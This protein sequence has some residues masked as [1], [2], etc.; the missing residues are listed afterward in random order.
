MRQNSDI[1]LEPGFLLK[2]SSRAPQ[3]TF[4]DKRKMEETIKG[5]TRTLL[6]LWNEEGYWWFT[7][8]ANEA[9]GAGFIQLMHFLEDVDSEIEKGLIQRM[10]QEQRED[11]SWGLYYAA[12]GDLSTTVECYLSLRLAGFSPS[13]APLLKAKKF[14]LSEGGLTQIRIFTRIHLALFG[15]I[16]WSNCPSMPAEMILLPPWAPMNVYHFSSWAR[17]SIIPLLVVM[18]TK[19]ALKIQGLDLEALYC[20]PPEKRKWTLPK[21]TNPLSLEQLFLLVDTG[22]KKLGKVPFKP[23]RKQVLD[24]CI[25]WIW[26]HIQKTHD[27]YPALAYGAMAFKACGYANETKQIQTALKALKSF[28]QRDENQM[29]QQCCISPVWDTPW[30]MVALQESGLITIDDPNLLKTG[31]WLLSKEIVN[32][33]GDWHFKNPEGEPGGWSFE[34]LNE[35]FPDVDDTIEVITALDN[36]DLPEEEKRPAIQRGLKW[37]LSM[38]N[39]DGGWGAFDKNNDLDLVNKIPFADHGACLDPSTPDIT[40]RALELLIKMGM[41]PHDKPVKKAILFLKK[42]QEKFGGWFGRWGVNYIYGT[43]CVLTGLN[44]LGRGNPLKK[45]CE[46]ACVWLQSIQHEDGGFSESPE[47]Y[48]TKKYCPYPE[49]VPSQTAWGLMGLIAGGYAESLAVQQGIS[50]LLE[51]FQDGVWEEKYFTGTGFPGHFYIRYHGY[52]YYFPLLALARYQK[53]AATFWS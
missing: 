49:S 18:N 30:A 48:V 24:R 29:H 22:L 23:W 50:F 20:E 1:P 8:E 46:K 36:L 45:E 53:V 42:S 4:I 32:P 21:K 41:G 27:I 38:Q 14:I 40:G 44:S 26:E 7:L 37:L 19:P 25:D 34:F 17:A 5:A 9:I 43:W 51:K 16:G 33:N 12:K 35:Y 13:S 10:L 2:K 47:S 39:D 3:T 52:R 11:G 31:R 28:Q 15:I 6:N